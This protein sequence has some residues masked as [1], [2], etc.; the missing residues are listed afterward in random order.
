MVENKEAT[1][2]A[3]YKDEKWDKAEKKYLALA[4]ESTESKHKVLSN[5]TNPTT[6]TSKYK[7]ANQKKL[8][9][10]IENVRNIYRW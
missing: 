3:H 6:S 1:W 10:I 5:K 4:S 2:L 9:N 7:R 8:K